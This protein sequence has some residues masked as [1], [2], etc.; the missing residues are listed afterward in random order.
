MSI[1][2]G[3]DREEALD[4]GTKP[5]RHADQKGRAGHHVPGGG[6]RGER[7]HLDPN[8]TP[9]PRIVDCAIP[10]PHRAVVQAELGE[11]RE[12]SLAKTRERTFLARDRKERGKEAHRFGKQFI[13]IVPHPAMA[14]G[15]A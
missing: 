14:K 11:L 10:P 13:N 6:A 1:L 5:K 15:D 9:R 2:K 4:F 7:P 3:E 12:G 8:M